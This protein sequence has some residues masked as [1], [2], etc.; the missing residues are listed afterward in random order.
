MEATHAPPTSHRIALQT[1]KYRTISGDLLDASDRFGIRSNS[2]VI[3]CELGP[4]DARVLGVRGGQCAGPTRHS[5]RHMPVTKIQLT[6]LHPPVSDVSSERAPASQREGVRN[7]GPA[8]LGALPFLR[9]FVPPPGGRS[10]HV[11]L[12]REFPQQRS[13]ERDGGVLPAQALG[14]RAM[15]PGSTGGIRR[16]RGDLFRLR[17]FLVF[18]RHLVRALSPLRRSNDRPAWSDAKQ[19]CR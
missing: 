12:V 3:G 7:G 11:A 13:L 9:G 5:Y 19:P 6:R 16:R 8:C 2:P 17:L 10:G 4:S 1:A 18:L 14:V 15:F